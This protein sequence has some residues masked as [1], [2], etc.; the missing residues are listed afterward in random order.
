MA[1]TARHRRA[2]PR[3]AVCGAAEALRERHG[4]GAAWRPRQV[5]G[6]AR[7][8]RAGRAARRA[9]VRSVCQGG[10]PQRARCDVSR[11]RRRAARRGDLVSP[12]RRRGAGVVGVRRAAQVAHADAAVP[13][14]SPPPRAGVVAGT[15]D[16]RRG[17]RRLPRQRLLAVGPAREHARPADQVRARR[18]PSRRRAGAIGVG[19]GRRAPHEL[20]RRL[21]PSAGACGASRASKALRRRCVRMLCRSTT[22]DMRPRGAGPSLLVAEKSS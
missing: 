3:L 11:S 4:A 7:S 15:R 16:V 1:S 9:T 8:A 12:A 20:V 22:S 18:R 21:R 19:V 14:P 17:S 2:A 10:E 5:A 6:R 13:W